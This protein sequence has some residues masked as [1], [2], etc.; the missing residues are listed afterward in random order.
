MQNEESQF[1]STHFSLSDLHYS[2]I[3]FFHATSQQIV[4]KTHQPLT[5][6]KLTTTFCISLFLLATTLAMAEEPFR[7]EPGKFPPA[8]K[9]KAYTGELVFVDHANRRGSLR[10]VG[11]DG[12]AY[13]TPGTPFAMLPYG[14][15]R[16]HGASVDLRDIPLGSVLHGRFYLP[17]DPK[18]SSVPNLSNRGMGRAG[19]QPAENHPLCVFI[20]PVLYRADHY[21]WV[22]PNG[23]GFY[24]GALW[25]GKIMRSTDGIHWQQTHPLPHHVLAL[26]YG[27]LGE[28]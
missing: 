8:D 2:F 7:P 6:M 27:K 5:A 20:S 13:G 10:I 15:I 28:A 11:D 21:C 19:K 1:L 17:P 23:I 14:M 12:Q 18:L 9:V 26:T 3:I 4:S 24:V 16:Y 25:P 22:A